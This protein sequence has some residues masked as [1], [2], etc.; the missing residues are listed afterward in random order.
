MR[1]NEAGVDYSK[2][3]VGKHTSLYDAIKHYEW[4]KGELLYLAHRE[5]TLYHAMDIYGKVLTSMQVKTFV[6]KDM[7]PIYYHHMMAN[8][9]LRDYVRGEWRKQ[10]DGKQ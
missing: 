6:E 4:E 10:Y 7:V 2:A 9:V 8:K 3:L 5:G 1:F